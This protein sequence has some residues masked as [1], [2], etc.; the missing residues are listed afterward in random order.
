MTQIKQRHTSY[1]FFIISLLLMF[2]IH[3]FLVSIITFFH[4]ITGYELTTI[5]TWLSEFKGPLLILIKSFSLYIVYFFSH[6][7][8]KKRSSNNQNYYD[9]IL[10]SIFKNSYIMNLKKNFS[11]NL[12]FSPFISLIIFCWLVLICVLRL[13]S[14]QTMVLN[15]EVSIWSLGSQ[16]VGVIIFFY[17][18]FVIWKILIKDYSSSDLKIKNILYYSLFTALIYVVF[19]KFFHPFL[20]FSNLFLF[21]LLS[22]YYFLMFQSKILKMESMIYLHLLLAPFL[23]FLIWNNI[24]I[25]VST[26]YLNLFSSLILSLFLILLIMYW[27]IKKIRTHLKT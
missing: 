4:F 3:L 9:V 2:L 12:L 5:E 15:E 19:I 13:S 7:F 10:S 22:P 18:D 8:R 27:K 24:R 25:D 21:M 23:T 26:Q 11:I 6:S 17:F 20:N 14:P 1:V 16:Y